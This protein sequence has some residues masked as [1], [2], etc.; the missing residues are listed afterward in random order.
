MVFAF[1]RPEEVEISEG[2]DVYFLAC[3]ALG[4]FEFGDVES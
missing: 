4:S 2:L 1:C 3:G